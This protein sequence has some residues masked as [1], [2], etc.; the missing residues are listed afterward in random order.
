MDGI[1]LPPGI[2][3]LG[4]STDPLEAVLGPFP[5]TRLRNLPYDVT[6][7]DILV[8]FQGLIVIDVI[9]AGGG[10][11]FVIFANPMDF[12]M[13]LQRN[14]QTLNRRFIE[15]SVSSRAEY[16]E[17]VATIHEQERGPKLTTGLGFRSD[18]AF[19][20]NDVR[21]EKRSTGEHS[22]LAALWG[23]P[24]TSPPSMQSLSPQPGFSDSLLLHAT[25]GMSLGG[26]SLGSATASGQSRVLHASVQKRAGGGI[27][28]GDHTGFLRM[29]GLPFSATKDDIYK[30]FNGYNP[31]QESIVL[32][33][34]NDGRATGEAYIG[35]GS[36]EDSKRAMELHRRTL[37]SRYIELFISNKD[38]Q[39]RA[40]ARF[41][42]R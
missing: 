32:T 25:S 21:E 36:P 7:E 16:Y 4:G 8:L 40:L 42:N 15:I 24:T 23:Q 39:G 5:C 28:I 35:F 20:R 1:P 18:E 33:Y 30:F 27:Q 22:A 3:G 26:R 9:L 37:G 38:E 29:R 34:R 2:P 19:R 31:V 6:L 13:A 11:A 10:E 41:G 12:Q 14:R 17:A